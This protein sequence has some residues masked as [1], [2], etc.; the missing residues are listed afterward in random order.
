METN[1][2]WYKEFVNESGWRVRIELVPRGDDVLPAELEYERFPRDAVKFAGPLTSGFKDLPLGLAETPSVKLQVELHLVS[3]ALAAIIQQPW[4]D[5]TDDFVGEENANFWRILSDLGDEEHAGDDWPDLPEIFTGFQKKEI[6]S[7]DEITGDHIKTEIEIVHSM[8]ILTERV[9]LKRWGSWLVFG[10]GV[11]NY[12]WKEKTRC[13]ALVA[14]RSGVKTRA[15]AYANLFRTEYAKFFQISTIYEALQDLLGFN[16]GILTRG[17]QTNFV[18]LNNPYTQMDWKKQLEVYGIG[19]DVGGGTSSANWWV[20]IKAGVNISGPDG[21]VIGYTAYSSGVD[22]SVFDLAELRSGF[23]L[24]DE[25]NAKWASAWDYLKNCA[26]AC[27]VKGVFTSRGIKFVGALE[28]FDGDERATNKKAIEPNFKIKRGYNVL[29]NVESRITGMRSI[30]KKQWKNEIE[31][32]VSE[33][34][35]QV[36]NIPFHNL[37]RR[38]QVK[39]SKAEKSVFTTVDFTGVTGSVGNPTDGNPYCEADHSFPP[40]NVW[41][42]KSATV[43][44]NVN[45]IAIRCEDDAYFNF[46]NGETSD[47]A[48][49]VRAGSIKTDWDGYSNFEVQQVENGLPKILNACIL[50]LYSRTNQALIDI[51]GTTR[52]GDFLYDKMQ[53]AHDFDLTEYAPGY[54]VTPGASC[55]LL[56]TSVDFNQGSFK[57]SLMP[58]G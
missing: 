34:K 10:A 41:Y 11:G 23:F 20:Y 30:D 44:L 14:R 58:R 49:W 31:A 2:V 1:K 42:F 25:N 4:A 48:G 51:E 40:N 38:L 45:E 53:Y 9:S 36:P 28:G 39:E 33:K 43:G 24:D 26:E 37:P 16:F 32:S 18:V 6:G 56:K 5:Y 21:W 17:S 19:P 46:G 3:P 27:F 7:E 57:A 47:T 35:W 29:K 54:Y 8:R 13:Y 50:W 55:H 12:A 15:F 52:A 22:Q